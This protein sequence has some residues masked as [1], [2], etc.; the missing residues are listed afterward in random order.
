V[1]IM[2]A[3][4]SLGT[5]SL[6]L[7]ASC[8]STAEGLRGFLSNRSEVL[9]LRRALASGSVTFDQIQLFVQQLLRDFKRNEKL[10][11]EYILAAIGVALE[12]F[13]G[14]FADDFL[15]ELAAI[16]TKELPLASRVASLALR[17]RNE[18]VPELTYKEKTFPFSRTDGPREPVIG[19][20]ESCTQR[21]EFDYVTAA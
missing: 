1:S 15:T 19:A 6:N 17:R 5:E 14:R 8:I 18:R 21:V 12:T 20:V 4:Q 10:T 9:D 7:A 13:P 3:L 2:I 16:R 11:N